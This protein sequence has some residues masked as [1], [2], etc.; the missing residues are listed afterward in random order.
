MGTIKLPAEQQREMGAEAKAGKKASVKPA[1]KKPASHIE[2]RFSL[3][4]RFDRTGPACTPGGLVDIALVGDLVGLNRRWL[5]SR[6]RM[7]LT[8][9]G[10][11][12]SASVSRQASSRASA[13][14]ATR[15]GHA[16]AARYSRSWPRMTELAISGAGKRV[17]LGQLNWTETKDYPDVQ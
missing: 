4:E 11:W 15:S 12:T 3:V 6:E 2:S 14:Y 7:A 1:A 17:T 13:R 5:S 8:K 9:R 16:G 10:C